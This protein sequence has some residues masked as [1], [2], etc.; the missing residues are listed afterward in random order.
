MHSV[1]E[2]VEYLSEFVTDYKNDLFRRLIAERTSYVTMVLED[3]YQQHNCSAVLRSCD[4]F[5]IQ[6]VHIIENMNTFTDN[7]EISMGASDWLTIHRHRKRENNT[8]ETIDILKSQGYRIIATTPHEQDTF[9]DQIDLHKGKMAFCMG[10]E[11]T[12]LSDDVLTRAD[13]FVKVPMYGF[14]ESYNVSVCAALLMY[15]VVQRL[16]QTEIDWHLSDEERDQV[17]F[18][19]YKRSIK[20]SA[21]ILKRFNHNV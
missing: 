9:I 4:C 12:G 1:K 16:R 13:E 6:N 2:Q 17:L 14:T 3:F 8:I 18:A 11:L 21:Q 20:A 10:T 19:W 5:G 15:S 7:S